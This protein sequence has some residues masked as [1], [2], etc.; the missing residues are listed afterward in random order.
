MCGVGVRAFKGV[1]CV[2]TVPATAALIP[3]TCRFQHVACTARPPCST[4]L[5]CGG[6]GNVSQLLRTTQGHSK[7]H[8]T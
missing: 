5:L 2:P 1:Y 4:Q 7:P 6:L 3:Y 8:P